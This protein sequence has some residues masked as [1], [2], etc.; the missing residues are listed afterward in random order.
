MPRNRFKEELRYFRVCDNQ[1]QNKEDRLG[2][3]GALVAHLNKHYDKAQPT[4]HS[5]NS[6]ECIIE[7]SGGHGSKQCIRSKLVPLGSKH[8]AY[9]KNQES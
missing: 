3:L 2:K 4:D 9:I 8:G 7:Y 1:K 6:D 5:F